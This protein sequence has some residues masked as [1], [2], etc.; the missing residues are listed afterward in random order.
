MLVE[1]RSRKLK[2]LE[3]EAKQKQKRPLYS[4]GVVGVCAIC[5]MWRPRCAKGEEEER[6]E[7]FQDFF[8]DL[9]FDFFLA[10]HVCSHIRTNSVLLF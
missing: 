10:P 4:S 8:W 9:M 1:S 2:R 6:L 3:M 7:K 5:V